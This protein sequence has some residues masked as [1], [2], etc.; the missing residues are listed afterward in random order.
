[1]WSFSR[2]EIL[3]LAA[4]LFGSF[5]LT[6]WLTA[7]G[8][9][10]SASHA[11]TP[12]QRLAAYPIATEYQLHHAA[13]ALGLQDEDAQALELH[14]APTLTGFVDSVERLNK[15]TVSVKGWLAARTG[16]GE[17]LH[18]LAF[19]G[20]KFAASART[21]G[22]RPDVTKALGLT[23]K[24]AQNVAYAMTFRCELGYLPI[25]VGLSADRYTQL[26]TKPC[27]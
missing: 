26:K 19:V 24:A 20:G 4:V 6:L 11:L 14:I 5:G 1:M 23:D 2:L 10:L 9:P 3:L 27:P 12:A 7:P 22:Q 17:P 16:D 21:H 8:G 15:D 25:L 18:L 13:Q